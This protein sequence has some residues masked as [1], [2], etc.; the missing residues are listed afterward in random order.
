M[1]EK[2]LFPGKTVN[3]AIACKVISDHFERNISELSQAHTA[4]N[5]A[6][7]ASLKTRID[8]VAAS[9]LGIKTRDEL[10]NAT[11]TLGNFIEPIK[12]KLSTVKT[13][14]NVIFKKDAATHARI[15]TKLGFT[16]KTKVVALSQPE[17]IAQ[18]ITFKRNLTPELNTEL[19]AAGIPRSLLEDIVKSSDPLVN[20]N[21]LQEMLK[22]TTKQAT[23]AVIKE[24]NALYEEI[25]GICK[26]A[27]NF[28]KKDPVKKEMFTFAKVLRNLGETRTE[29][30]KAKVS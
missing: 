23:D 25:I 22:G 3:M 18:L 1:S 16:S 24:F 26:I 6:Y 12:E 15:L 7:A 28:Y 4:W 2:H 19:T 29:P 30:E 5:P 8:S 21:S 13:Q 17:L 27:S 14:V 11:K 20:A 10:F 9:F